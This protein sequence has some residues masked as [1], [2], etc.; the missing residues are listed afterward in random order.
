MQVE[1]L[2]G[3]EG[4]AA[5]DLPILGHIAW[6]TVRECKAPREVVELALTRAGLSPNLLP[7][8][9][10]R[11]AFRRACTWADERVRRHPLDE[12]RFV[13]ILVRPVKSSYQHKELVSQVVV[14][15]VSADDERLDYAP[16]ANLRLDQT[17]NLAVEFLRA[18][19]PTVV[20][21]LIADVK[22]TYRDMLTHC[23]GAH[24]RQVV[25]SALLQTKPVSVRPSG[26]VWF[27]KRDQEATLTSLAQFLDEIS[28]Y[29][30]HGAPSR[31]WKVPV[32]DGEEH[33]L[34]VR[35][36]LEEQTEAEAHKTIED[37]AALLK[38]E[39]L[40]KFQVQTCVE[41]LR[42]LREQVEAYEELLEQRV[43]AAR[44]ALDIAQAQLRRLLDR[45]ADMGVY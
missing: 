20:Y 5:Q 28:Q 2:V 9:N 36:A 34:M 33:R 25:Y 42:H 27:V 3:V 24:I 12:G 30:V 18:E 7:R 41:R 45:A 11:D 22:V 37:I 19:F 13:N 16:V 10:N 4:A 32:V 31:L 1:R 38:A 35:E 8:V 14:E 43:D 29:N 44:A 21:E 15:I 23:S 17:G 39:K 40:Q 26:G 6:Y